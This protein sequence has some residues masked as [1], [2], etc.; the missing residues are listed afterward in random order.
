[1]DN[2]KPITDIVQTPQS[3]KAKSG[4]VDSICA[5]QM[6]MYAALT[7]KAKLQ[8][9]WPTEDYFEAEEGDVDMQIEV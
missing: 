3:L 2:A 4:H 8:V 9:F 1:M 7:D 6:G 5:G